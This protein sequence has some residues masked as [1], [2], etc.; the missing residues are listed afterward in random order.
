M[1]RSARGFTLVELMLAMGFVSVL[2]LSV[3]LVAIQTGRMY[4]RGATLRTVNQSGRTLS[5]TIRRD[6]LQARTE[7]IAL[8]DDG[9]PVILVRDGGAVRSGRMC[10]GSYSY[11]WNAAETLDLYRT[12]STALPGVVTLDNKPIGAVRLLD[13]GAALCQKSDTGGYPLAL[14]SSGAAAT[15]LLRAPQDT[16]DVPLALYDVAAQRLTAGGATEALYR[17]EFTLGTSAT[18]ELN[19]PKARQAGRDV[20]CKAPSEEGANATFCAVNRFDMIVRTNG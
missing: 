9:R 6:F 5:D 12:R 7:K 19:T 10:L 13:P 17:I 8:G 1:N 20:S 11:V 2:L 3:A 14:S 4:T 16:Q 15:H 18:G